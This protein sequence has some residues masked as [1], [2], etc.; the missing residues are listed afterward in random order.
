MREWSL[1]S[2][3]C[4]CLFVTRLLSPASIASSLTARLL[5]NHSGVLGQNT[6]L[7]RFCRFVCGE[8]KFC[9]PDTPPAIFQENIQTEDAEIFLNY[10]RLP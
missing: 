10:A 2:P 7:G 3:G 6:R 4:R 9:C 1:P 8:G 5:C